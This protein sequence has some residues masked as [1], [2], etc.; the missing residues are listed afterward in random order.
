M[1][2][3]RSSNTEVKEQL[4]SL[5]KFPSENPNPVL[6]VTKDGEVLYSNEAGKSLL[7]K[8]KAKVGEKVPEKWINL[9]DQAFTSGK[10]KE[11]EEKVKDKV[12]SIVVTPINEAG[13]ANLYARDI[14]EVKKTQ[15]ILRI[16][17]ERFRLAVIESPFPIMIHAEDGEVLQ[18]SKVWTELTG[19]RPQEIPTLSAWTERAYGEL[20]DIV[21]S[22]ID[23][24]FSSKARVDEG[25]YVISSKDGKMLIW[26]FSSAP[27]GKL[28]DGRRLV[29]SMAKDITENKRIEEQ[30]EN[31][32]RFP[33]ENPNPVLRIAK[34]G[35]LLYANDA[36]G[37]LLTEWNCREGEIM[38]ENWQQIVS[39]AFTT[40]LSKKIEIEHA[41]R[42]FAFM[43][44]PVLDA[45]YANL[46]ARDITERKQAEKELEKT[47]DEL[48]TRVQERTK[49]LARTVDILQS[50]VAE[51]MRLQKEVLEISEEEQRRI[52][53]ELHDGLQQ[54]LVGMTFEC[55]L[56][57]KRLTAKSLPEADDAARIHRFL[58]DAIDHTRAITRMLYPIDLDSKDISFALKQLAS[59]VGSLF[60]ISCQFT[61]KESLVVQRPE[62]VINIYRIVQEAVTNAIKH[63]KADSISISL[64]SSKNKTTFTVRD[65]GTGLA[66]DY[67]ETEGMG[68]RIM[69]YRS[70]VIGASLNIKS[71]TR[72][73]GTAVTCSFEN[74][75]N[76]LL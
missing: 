25:E 41:G 52:G 64:K 1:E 63:G 22:Q 17:E 33:S 3:A 72:G 8:W 48:E 34:D 51:R 40:G 26:D 68:L 35:V 44:V 59:R 47:N 32:A 37:T 5:A 57:N 54:E 61:G 75:D 28:P 13:Y 74:K 62:V 39:E 23:K 36:G 2:K 69:K 73:P 30:I 29:I 55:Q 53:R 27:L 14:T 15:E 67:G 11:E 4:E 66:T 45:G 58:S 7:A 18:I 31:L 70:S 16:S 6:R 21:K 9:I 56:L 50:E 46:Y 20:K 24:L 12:F 60:H 10:G 76:N 49:E 43:V 42:I 38:S 65:N 19:Y 71:N